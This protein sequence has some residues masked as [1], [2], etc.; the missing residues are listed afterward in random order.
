MKRSIFNHNTR[1]PHPVYGRAIQALRQKAQMMLEQAYDAEC[2]GQSK[3]TARF[4]SQAAALNCAAAF[5]A[6]CRVS[7]PE[8]PPDKNSAPAF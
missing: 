4:T 3:R 8:Q 6:D 5:L 7:P 1:P 2:R